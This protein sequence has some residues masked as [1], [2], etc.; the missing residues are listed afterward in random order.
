MFILEIRDHI[1]HTLY[2]S[3]TL[4]KRR[5]FRHFPPNRNSMMFWNKKQH[6]IK[7][8]SFFLLK[9]IHFKTKMC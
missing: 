3:D 4:S 1:K 5:L 9:I 6:I 8:N 7:Y 2:C